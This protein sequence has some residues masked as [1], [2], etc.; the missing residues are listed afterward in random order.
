MREHQS[1]QGASALL[2]AASLLFLFGAAVLAVDVSGFY[3]AATTDQTTADMSCLAG[4]AEL[5]DT[6]AAITAAAE[7]TK[8][9]WPQTSLSGPTIAGT[10]GVMT[11]GSGNIV[12]IDAAYGGASDQMSITVSEQADTNFGRVLGATA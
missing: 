11:D 4:V 7:I 5:P 12:T 8:L 10:T 1:E 3:Q 6:S 2:V 9:N